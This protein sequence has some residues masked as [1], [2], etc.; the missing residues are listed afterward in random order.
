MAN[1]FDNNSLSHEP[2]ISLQAG[3]G[4]NY[5]IKEKNVGRLKANMAIQQVS[6]QG[7]TNSIFTTP[8]SQLNFLLPI[9]VSN[10]IDICQNLVFEFQ[11]TN[12][13]G[14]SALTLLPI[15]F[16]FNNLQVLASGSILE[17][18]Y[19]ENFILDETFWQ[20]DDEH[21]LSL[22]TLENF[23]YTPSGGYVTNTTTIPANG[24]KT[25]Y[26]NL[27]CSLNRC[28]LFLSAINS[29]ITIQFQFNTA[30]Y[31]AASASTSVSLTSAQLIMSGFKYENTIRNK[32]LQ[33]FNANTTLYSYYLPRRE[34]IPNLSLSN[35]TTTQVQ[36]TSFSGEHVSCLFV[37]ARPSGAS[38]DNLYAF[39]QLSQIDLKNA[40]QSVF[41]NGL[42]YREYTTMALKVIPSSAGYS[43]NY[44]MMPFS[45]DSYHS[46]I[47]GV[48]R[49]V[50]EFS[51]NFAVYVLDSVAATREL[52][53]IAYQLQKVYIKGGNLY[54]DAL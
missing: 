39:D 16:M 22:Q 4:L 31:T 1:I 36:V 38:Q 52:V 19:P 18:L 29:Q 12:T 27:Q 7:T 10:Q 26:F 47:D 50:L 35:V 23:T 6:S 53:L 15:P 34:V 41:L 24:S 9:G 33:R 42:N 43:M 32:L 44:F 11:I 46:V 8:N 45:I 3:S 49:G 20:E 2:V 37:G 25:F 28:E 21:I 48:Q 14:A 13:S 5:L 17:T 40:G 30:P 51:P 54:M